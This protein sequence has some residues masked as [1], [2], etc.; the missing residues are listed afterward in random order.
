M[1]ESPLALEHLAAEVRNAL[2]SADLEAYRDLLDPN[3]TWGAPG[4]PNPSCR[5]RDEVLTWYRRGRAEGVRADVTEA[6]VHGDAIL[7]G[8]AIHGH[9]ADQRW[10]V[11]TVAGGKVVDIRGFEDRESAVGSLT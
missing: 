1:P 6:T 8:L 10:Q 7:V 9:D 4:D 3:V 5:N 11:L 2:G